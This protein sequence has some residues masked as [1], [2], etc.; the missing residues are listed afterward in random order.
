M[1][2]AASYRT[3]TTNGWNNKVFLLSHI[4]VRME[5]VPGWYGSSVVSSRS[6]S[7]STFLLWHQQF[8]GAVSFPWCSNNKHLTSTTE[9]KSKKKGKGGRLL[10]CLCACVCIYFIKK[11]IFPQSLPTNF[12]LYLI[13]QEN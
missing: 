3:P 5:V 13:N 11:E 4:T 9:F 7:L 10:E 1:L 2:S 6:E 12:P 8:M